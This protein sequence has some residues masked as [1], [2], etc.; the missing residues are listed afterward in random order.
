MTPLPSSPWLTID[1]C[2]H[3]CSSLPARSLQVDASEAPFRVMTRRHGAHLTFSPMM[4]SYAFHLAIDLSNS[5][6]TITAPKKLTDNACYSPVF[7]RSPKHRA[8][9]H[10]VAPEDRPLI[11]Q[12]CGTDAETVVAAAKHIEHECDGVDLNLG[13]PQRCARLGGYGAFLPDQPEV[14]YSIVNAMHQNLTVPASCKI[15][16]N[17]DTDRAQSLEKTIDFA[18]KL[19]AHGCQLLTIHGRT[20]NMK[21]ANA[22]HTDWAAIREIK[23]HLNI[24]VIANGSIDSFADIEP[25]MQESTADA[26]MAAYSMLA[27]P[28]LF[29]NIDLRGDHLGRIKAAREY[30]AIVQE[31]P[32]TRKYQ[33]YHIFSLLRGPYVA[34]ITFYWITAHLSL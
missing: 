8:M 2:E 13:C 34:D 16:L 6:R 24:P 21:G 23:R 31:Y 15:R 12:F 33:D 20:R 18:V 5:L 28:Y 25:C 29:E 4:Y 19:Q 32:T 22:P 17:P 3:G 7:A 10:S 9:I 30:M 14:V 26:V 1:S 11:I 27:N